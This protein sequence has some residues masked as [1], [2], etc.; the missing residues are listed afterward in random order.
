MMQGSSTSDFGAEAAT[1]HWTIELHSLAFMSDNHDSNTVLVEPPGTMIVGHV[2]DQL[3]EQVVAVKSK[4]EY[5]GSHRFLKV[6]GRG[7]I[8]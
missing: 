2:Q 7:R 8:A 4:W 3:P 1:D 5:L 6:P